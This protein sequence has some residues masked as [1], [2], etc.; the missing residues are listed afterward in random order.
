MLR[1]V[2]FLLAVLFCMGMFTALLTAFYTFRAYFMTF[3]GELRVPPEAGHHAHES[4]PSM[5]IPLWILSIGA[6]CLGLAVGH[7]TG[8]FDA[9]LGHTLAAPEEHHPTNET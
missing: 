6:A 9:F 5:C 3:H 7:L 4:P 8:I 1:V 2:Y